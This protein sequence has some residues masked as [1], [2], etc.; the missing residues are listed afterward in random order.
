[1][2]DPDIS[3]TVRRLME[4]GVVVHNPRTVD[5]GPEVDPDR[6]SREGVVV[7]G[8]T[9]IGGERTVLSAGVRLGE[10][11]PVTVIN[12][13][14]GRNVELKSG[15]FRESVFL[16][17]S[18]FGP[19]AHVREG[20]LVE[21]DA[22]GAHSVGLKQTILFPFVTLGSL[23]NFCDCL[24]AGGTSRKD[25][26]EVGSSYI[27]F[28]YTPN[29]DKATASLIGDVPRGVMLRERPI[30]LGGQGGLI[31]PS[32]VGYGVVVAAGTILGDDVEDGCLVRDAGS[33]RSAQTFIPGYYGN[34]LRIINNNIIYMANLTALDAW[35]RH[36]RGYFFEHIPLGKH[37]LEGALEILKN[38]R[39]ERLKRVEELAEKMGR[40]VEIPR[41][42]SNSGREEADRAVC[43]A[44]HLNWRKMKEFMNSF[45]A[46]GVCVEE[47]NRFVE[48][49]QR[50]CGES[51]D[52]IG[53][54][55]SLDNASR[56]LGT[57]WLRGIVNG[58]F[59]GS[60]GSMSS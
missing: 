7:F 10:E 28:N 32:R 8:G 24:M 3:G 34:P 2:V 43:R 55:R 20:C 13:R 5:I 31:G 21:E 51:K 30:F 26:S 57:S 44:F 50:K 25:H 27:H 15:S 1:M 18:N 33:G 47:R 58:M 42:G 17:R 12:C 9:R 53:A 54:V 23:V 49:F 48:A 4:R 59:D 14:L 40:P 29:Q 36:A 16:D 35:Y 56:E 52:Y 60:R 41:R 38:A 19:G 39:A 37:L 22:G 11:G 45:D 46:D 6:I